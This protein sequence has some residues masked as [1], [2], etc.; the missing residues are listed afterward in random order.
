MD[1]FPPRRRWPDFIRRAK[2]PAQPLGIPK[3]E[4]DVAI[5]RAFFEKDDDFA[6]RALP[7][8]A[9]LNASRPVA[10]TALALRAAYLD[11]IFHRSDSHL[12]QLFRARPRRNLSPQCLM[13][14]TPDRFAVNEY[15]ATPPNLRH[16]KA[17]LKNEF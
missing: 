6:V 1:V 13:G 4:L 10:K 15:G 12:L 8:I 17:Q 14:R 5:D 7:R 3:R 11:G 9:A 2:R 16:A